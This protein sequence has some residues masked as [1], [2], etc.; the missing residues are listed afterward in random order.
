MSI[1]VLVA[2]GSRARLLCAEDGGSALTEIEDFVHPESRLRQQELVSDG[3]GSGNDSV[4]RGRHSMGHENAAHRQQEADFARELGSEIDRV[5][6]ANQP[7]RIYLVAPP[8][9]LG[10]LRDHLSKQSTALLAG[11]IDKNLVQHGIDEIRAHLPK[12]M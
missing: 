6:D 11:E 8:R 7:H 3:P 9:F 2:D 10:E 4:G 1:I 12:R 5:R